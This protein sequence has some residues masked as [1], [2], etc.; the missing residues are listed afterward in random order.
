MA[1]RGLER[2]K[3]VA[4]RERFEKLPGYMLENCFLGRILACL[5]YS[6]RM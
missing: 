5:A 4:G 6:N 3:M 1:G 2:G